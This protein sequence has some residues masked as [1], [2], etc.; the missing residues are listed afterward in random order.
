M[1]LGQLGGIC[2]LILKY[3]RP[4]T[5]SCQSNMST[6]RPFAIQGRGLLAMFQEEPGPA[7]SARGILAR[8]IPLQNRFF[9]PAPKRPA[10]GPAGIKDLPLPGQ[11]RT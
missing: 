2:P 6:Q 3:R 1:T 8:K 4:A 11:F 5:V 7:N 10:R 9:R